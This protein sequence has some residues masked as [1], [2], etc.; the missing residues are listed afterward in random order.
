MFLSAVLGLKDFNDLRSAAF[1]PQVHNFGNIGFG[2]RVHAHVAGF[3]TD[4]IDRAAYKKPLRPLLAKHIAKSRPNG[5]VMDVGCG[6]GTLTRELHDA[7][8]RVIG[9]DASSEMIEM[10]EK[11]NPD[12]QFRVQNAADVDGEEQFDVAVACMLAHEL[13]TSAHH[14]LLS[15]MIKCTAKNKGDVWISDIVPTYRPSQLMLSGEPYIENY[16]K[17]FFK[18]IKS[19]CES[20]SLSLE[21][22]EIVFDR[23]IAYKISRF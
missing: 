17:T 1:H 6:V 21:Y 3:A 4:L 10:A 22:Y 19:V 7:G 20:N 15:R 18:T 14:E 16:L 9:I 13:P 2:G 11:K 23:V 12:L 8:M 5:L